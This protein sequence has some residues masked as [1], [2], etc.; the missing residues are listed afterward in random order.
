M[1]ISRS[2]NHICLLCQ[3]N[4]ADKKGSHYTPAGLIKREIGKRDYE[5][6]YS[7]NS[8]QASAS[9]FKGRSNL[10]N[11]DTSIRQADHIDDYIFCSVC[12][13]QLATIESECNERLVQFTD[14][15]IKGNLAI[16][17]TKNGH[18]YIFLKKP[19]KNILSLFFYSVIWRQCIQQKLE[20]QSIF[21]TEEFQENLRDIIAKEI[22]KPLNE[23]E[24]SDNFKNYPGLI[25]LTTYHKGDRTKSWINPNVT[26]SNPELFFIGAFKALIFI[27][28]NLTLDFSD[29]TALPNSTVDNEL[30]INISAQS[31]VGIINEDL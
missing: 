26:P 1:K 20:F 19:G 7:I 14:D 18:K 25:I 11:T 12:E 28:N 21:T 17:K 22:A 6:I 2:P 5:E 16:R 9:V 15:L 4:K 10:S 8:F 3:N 31:I 23:I 27:S 30:I 13:K 29:R 24:Q